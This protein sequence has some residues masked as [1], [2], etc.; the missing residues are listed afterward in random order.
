M[1]NCGPEIAPKDQPGRVIGFWTMIAKAASIIEELSGQEDSTHQ[2]L[3][4]SH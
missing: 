2:L 1:A 3:I 4:A